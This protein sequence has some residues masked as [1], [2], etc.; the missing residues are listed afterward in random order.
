MNAPTLLIGLGGTGCRIVERV[1]RLAT[2]EQRDS[3]AYAVFDTDVN[4]LRGIKER[5]PFIHTI[6]T[7]TKQTVGEYISKDIHASSKWFPMNKILNRK[8]MTEGAGQVR[9]VSRLAFEAAMRAG[10]LEPLHEAIQSLFKVEEDKPD[11]SVRVI[12]VSSLAGGTGSGLILP[13]GLYVRQYL[14]NHFHKSSSIFRGFFIL[15]EVFYN[16]ISSMSERNNL[17]ANAYATLREL[18]AF[19]MKGDGTLPDKYKRT[20]ELEMPSGAGGAYEDYSKSPYDYC[21]L[22]DAQ[23]AEGG[24]LNSFNQYLDHAANCIYSQSIGPMNKRSNSSEDNTI[25]ALARERG[26]NRYAGAGA[27]MLIYPVNDIKKFIALKWTSECVSNQW[28]V[29]DKVYK[30]I[31]IE[32]ASKRQKGINAPNPEPFNFYMQQIDNLK[33][34]DDPFAKA[35]YNSCIRFK[36]DGV[37]KD[38]ALW[39]RY[40]GVIADKTIKDIHS[41]TDTIAD[42]KKK[43]N[44]SLSKLNNSN[45]WEDYVATYTALQTYKQQYDNNAAEMLSSIAYNMFTAPKDGKIDLSKEFTLEHFMVDGDGH[46]LHPNAIRFNLT[47]ILDYMKQA[48][49]QYEA[50]KT[51]IKSKFDRFEDEVFDDPETTEIKETVR[52]L[53]RRK[54]PLLD[55]LM[56]RPTSDQ[57]IIRER[58]SEYLNNVDKYIENYVCSSVFEE[59]IQHIESILKSFDL[60]YKSFESKVSQLDSMVNDIYNRY[61]NNMGTTIRYVCASKECLDKIYEQKPFTGNSLVIDPELSQTIYLKIVEHASDKDKRGGNKYFSDLFDKGII[62]FFESTVMKQYGDDI[63]ID[64]ISAIEREAMLT[65]EFDEEENIDELAKRYVSKTI[66]DT[67]AL[68]CPFIESPLGDNMQEIKACTFNDSLVPDSMDTSSRALLIEKELQ[69]FG[70]SP[71]ES[72]PRNMI[73]FY[74]SFYGLRANDLSKFAPPEKSATH[75]RDGGE[76]FKAYYELIADIH[77]K[78]ELSREISPHIDRMWHIISKMPDLDDDNQLVQ[79]KAI[80]TAFFWGIACKFIMYFDDGTENKL[81]KIKVD[82][83]KMDRD[84]L[85]VSNG[86]ECD[87]FYEVLDAVSLYPELVKKIIAKIDAIITDDLNEN[88]PISEGLLVNTLKDFLISEPGLGSTHKPAVSIFDIPM[89]MRKSATHDNFYEEDAINII[90]TELDIIKNYLSRFCT[91]RELPG[92]MSQIVMEQFE[93][94]LADSSIELEVR[95]NLYR[96]TLFDRTCAIIEDSLRSIGAKKDADS[97]K[98]RA[99]EL[100]G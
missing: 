28:L 21:F 92:V 72:I 59:G 65:C 79:E 71:D 62:G 9:A 8:T 29:I 19:L 37:T 23:N 42:S 78:A 83:L 18:D 67:R 32:N 75:S 48:R 61:V 97:I 68:S 35:I 100:R 43:A 53:P 81:Y 20:V 40:V 95:P 17:K 7:S 77:P 44:Q 64:I 16:V 93:K 47:H 55:K 90:K 60:F 94:Y 49:L 34:H 27:S 11:Q 85:Y 30:E 88:T 74:Q 15:P 14:D 57:E 89:I 41:V 3:I 87:K 31:C 4:D 54:V 63:D 76:Y 80:Y 26:R 69:N 52:D 10:M 12:I 1:S 84:E 82:T 86:T 98:K 96:E 24:K 45:R 99:V 66:A 6:Q 70:G 13:V 56:K 5:N 91:K 50:E 39:D 58:Y 22:F 73:M 36:P 2:P 46:F 25:R 51:R 33:E 38:Y